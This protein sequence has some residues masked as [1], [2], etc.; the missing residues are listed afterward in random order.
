MSIVEPIDGYYPI[1]T[2]HRSDVLGT[3]DGVAIGELDNDF[4]LELAERMETDYLNQLYWSSLE[5]IAKEL[6]SQ[7]REENA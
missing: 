1:T 4:M 2:V 6:L 7:R 3:L 5:I